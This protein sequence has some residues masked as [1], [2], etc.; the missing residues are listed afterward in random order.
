MSNPVEASQGA[1]LF[2]G[3][4]GYLRKAPGKPTSVPGSAP[5]FRGTKNTPG[6]SVKAPAI[7]TSYNRGDRGTNVV[8]PYARVVPLEHLHDVGR[9]SPGDVVFAART[10]L[11]PFG[12]GM[13]TQMRLVGIDFLNRELGGRPEYDRDKFS[14]NW[15]VGYNV[16]LGS[17]DGAIAGG[18]AEVDASNI[19]V[20]VIADE[21]RRLT[22][23]REWA[24]DGVVLSND[25]PHAHNSSGDR[26]GQLFNI[27]I[28]GVCP[29]NN[30]YVDF[31]GS[32]VE[33]SH[34]GM[35]ANRE[36]Y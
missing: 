25:Q 19:I 13:E 22:C 8:I 29:V 3:L 36:G 14:M 4:A 26:D 35:T 34:R 11:T 7:R 21:W 20:N 23:L 15:Q 2:G 27:A 33:S 1:P 9:V 6:E 30:G 32:G 10:K 17:E 5:A 12:R 24:C 18:R 28:Q 16:L 31:K